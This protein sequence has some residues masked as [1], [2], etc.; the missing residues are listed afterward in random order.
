[1]SS[2]KKLEL[3]ETSE[4]YF[5]EGNKF[6]IFKNKV[7][8]ITEIDIEPFISSYV[9]EIPLIS[10][11]SDIEGTINNYLKLFKLLKKYL[12]ENKK[13]IDTESELEESE[14]EESD[15]NSNESDDELKVSNHEQECKQQ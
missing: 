8:K 9:N 4:K 13:E 2:T 12:V 1:M 14:L 11:I 6:L 3:H 10:I 7:K 5:Y 15:N